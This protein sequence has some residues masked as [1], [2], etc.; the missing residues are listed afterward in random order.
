ML[1]TIASLSDEGLRDA[2]EHYASLLEACPK[3]HV[4]DDATI[5]R[6]K[7]VNGESLEW[8]DVY[9]RQLGR[10]QRERLTRAQREEVTRLQGMQRDLRKVLT[11]ILELADE[12]GRGRSNASSP[13]AISSWAWSS[14]WDRAGGPDEPGTR[15][16]ASIE[17]TAYPRSRA[18][19]P[20]RC[21]CAAS[22][23]SR[24]RTTS[25]RRSESSAA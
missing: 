21:C 11:Q 9:D 20:R 1:A 19:S 12:L 24:A 7:R 2:R 16:M 5:A 25:T 23:P 6:T 14:C 10:W 22:E 18:A 3:P 17:R 4:L 8:C 15:A 13:R